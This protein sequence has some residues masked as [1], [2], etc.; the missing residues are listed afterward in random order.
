M[1]LE[2]I[3]PPELI[4]YD[5]ETLES[6]IINRIKL[7]P[8][9]K[10]NY[11]GM[12]HHDALTMIISIFTYL[13][14]KNAESFDRKIRDVFLQ[15]AYSD[16]AK[17]FNLNEKNILLKQNRESVTTIRCEI[18]DNY[19][20]KKFYLPQHII[21]TGASSVNSSIPFE[22]IRKDSD[23]YD[24]IFPIEIEPGQN[25]TSFNIEAYS[26]L[27]RSY[28]YSITP[29]Q[30]KFEIEVP[31]IN[32]IEGSIKVYFYL[33]GYYH[34]L[35]ENTDDNYG[36]V[37]FDDLGVFPEGSP[38]YILN[39]GPNGSPIIIFGSDVF[40]GQFKTIHS[41][42]QIVVFARYGGGED[43]NIYLNSINEV[44][45]IDI[46]VNKS[47][48]IRFTNITEGVGGADAELL[49]DVIDYILTRVGRGKQIVDRLDAK[50][51]LQQFIN[52]YKIESPDYQREES[53]NIP[54][55][56][57][58]HYIVP[59]KN[60]D[61]FVFP[62][63]TITQTKDEYS[64]ILVQALNNYLNINGSHSD[65][66]EDELLSNFY[67]VNDNYSITKILNLNPILS[68]SLILKAYNSNDQ[69]IDRI[70][71][72]GNYRL[73]TLN[74][75]RDEV[76]VAKAIGGESVGSV[77]IIVE[78]DITTEVNNSLMFKFD[79]Y[80]LIFSVSFQTGPY[81]L[82]E[83]VSRIKSMVEIQILSDYEFH[84][85]SELYTKLISEGQIN[86]FV[87]I[88]SGRIYFQSLK[89]NKE[90]SITLIGEINSPSYNLFKD[91]GL[92]TG[93]Y[94]PVRSHR[95]FL[96]T[97]SGFEYSNNT[98]YVYTDET[99]HIVD[100]YYDV[101][102]EQNED[103][104]TGPIIVLD[105]YD[106]ILSEN[107]RPQNNSDMIISF[108]DD[109]VLID[110]VEIANINQNAI[111]F[112]SYDSGTRP[113]ELPPV[114]RC[115][116]TDDS[117]VYNI[118]TST[119]TCE[120]FDGIEGD[121]YVSPFIATEGNL[122]RI[123][124]YKITYDESEEIAELV[125]SFDKN[126]SWI[127]DI[128][129]SDGSEFTLFLDA[130]NQLQVGED[131]RADIYMLEEGETEPVKKGE[132]LFD[133]IAT[134]LTYGYTNTDYTVEIFDVITSNCL[135]YN[136]EANTIT[137]KLVL[138]DT[139]E[140]VQVYYPGFVY[141]NKIRVRFKKESYDYITANYQP[142]PYVVEG[143][144]SLY[145]DILN[146]KS[147]RLLALE[148]VIKT[149]NIYPVIFELNLYVK[150][151]YSLAIAAK[152]AYRIL[153]ENFKFNNSNPYHDIDVSININYINDI[154]ISNLSNIGVIR[155]EIVSQTTYNNYIYDED[156]KHFYMFLVEDEFLSIIKTSL[157]N[158][159]N[160]VGIENNF[161]LNINPISV[162][163]A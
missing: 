39:Y 107:Y 93:T 63:P 80:D 135:K 31:Y 14:G 83:I 71:F 124:L 65:L 94:L 19:F 26:G 24:Y 49:D 112:I 42:G 133:D 119:L 123:D 59:N 149:I 28:N 58:Y 23:G 142:D 116:K 35:Q 47:V 99:E 2:Q 132:V 104:E 56:H 61:N 37:I 30:N 97:S 36:Q 103:S 129:N 106:E 16:E 161:K 109:E 7:H 153:V 147:K 137:L 6:E 140:E 115:L 74:Y 91:L 22:I 121:Q 70:Y 150:E 143:E 89:T 127:Q 96:E 84:G 66:V 117:V 81:T 82:S 134:Y 90:S 118:Q 139:D 152:E 27:T 130:A 50:N 46:D 43:S 154:L 122:E 45:T 145:M 77:Q 95:V 136:R 73:N 105:L 98:V 62:T 38:K 131:Y 156:E 21:L 126:E 55:W 159:A 25:F 146:R 67:F 88:E 75:N 86:T 64:N 18:I 60:F 15:S 9:W 162:S 78:S 128:N 1:K 141:F 12:L 158:Y 138:P 113:E 40:C 53:N 13:F 155:A 160:L 148:N 4:N 11:N 52:K 163:V 51:N 8:K 101:E 72:D 100:N 44:Q 20:D 120:L 33:N 3:L 144:A 85:L 157:S 48:D 68:N 57:D 151:N 41:S 32:V 69:E 29:N 114:K 76:G 92:T 34:L 10:D 111:S 79:N 5:R 17:V 108:Y 125:Q 54:M 110:E 102:I 87:G